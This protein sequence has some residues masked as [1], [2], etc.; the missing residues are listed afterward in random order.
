MENAETNVN[1][2]KSG[3]SRI[4][5]L[6]K[7]MPEEKRK[8]IF[9][10]AIALCV[11]L[12]T[13]LSVH[14]SSYQSTD[15]AFVDSNII[16]ISPK[17]SG[18]VTSVLINSNKK[19]KKGDLLIEIEPQDYKTK[20]EQ[21]EARLEQIR[22]EKSQN[23]EHSSVVIAKIKLDTSKTQLEEAQQKLAAASAERKL[24]KINF[25]RYSKLYEKGAVAEQKYNESE[26]KL[27]TAQ[28]EYE[29]A[30]NL[31]AQANYAI[32]TATAQR[33]AADSQVKDLKAQLKQASLDLSYTSIYA[34]ID[35]I[36]TAKNV[37]AGNY[38]QKGQP[39]FSIVPAQRWITANFKE[40]QL[41]NIKEGQETDIKIDA[42]P[43]LKF[44]GYV[45]SIQSATGSKTSLFPPENAVGSYVKIVQRVPVK[46]LFK[47]TSYQKY[48][49]EPGMS[50]VPKVKTR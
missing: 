11:V 6:I 46:I 45:E 10:G 36:I 12:F 4:K 32:Q 18:N 47:D 44:K 15:D 29:N 48:H 30:L 27:A 25:D 31:V 28:A 8:K 39:L 2:T 21:F 9:R 14:F 23:T 22:G 41:T 7:Q 16:Q 37:E 38:V 24:A 42:F 49:I 43:K 20:V 33:L 19:V 13:V 34:P 1:K 17:V 3:K 40:T 5:N 26:T 50:A 35:G